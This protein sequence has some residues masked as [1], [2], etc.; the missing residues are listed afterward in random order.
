MYPH[1][2]RNI[3]RSGG[4]AP[5]RAFYAVQRG[6]KVG[7]YNTWAECEAQVRSFSGASYKKF[8]TVEEALNFVNGTPSGIPL[9]SESLA[10]HQHGSCARDGPAVSRKRLEEPNEQR[11]EAPSR[12]L[13]CS[14]LLAADAPHSQSDENHRS[15]L[16]FLSGGSAASAASSSAAAL[17]GSNSEHN[18]DV[19]EVFCDGSCF[20]NGSARAVAGVGVYFGSGSCLNVSEPLEGP[21][22]TNQRAELTA[23]IRVFERV[24]RT[25]HLI[26][27]TDSR[28]VIKIMTEWL[29]SWKRSSWYRGKNFMHPHAKSN[30]D[31]ITVLDAHLAQHTG[32]VEWVHVDAHSGIPGNEAAD[33][34][35]R[36][37]SY[38]NLRR[39]G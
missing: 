20:H 6:R 15:G 23:A 5:A 4:S 35:A 33:A 31:L 3:M 37:G 36:E 14:R 30:M 17:S 12:P 9:Q 34:L 29:Q 18:S 8:S 32:H 16:V 7:I 28:Y 2:V 39:R 38:M 13:K 1:L 24:P 27:K 26:I 22:Q 10:H 11:S 21:V 19:I 25:A